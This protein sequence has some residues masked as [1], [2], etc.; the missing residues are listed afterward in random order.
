M[1]AKSK[2]KTASA[3]AEQSSQMIYEFEAIK[4]GSRLYGTIQIIDMNPLEIGALQSA[5]GRACVGMHGD[6]HV[7][8]LGGKSSVG[9][10]RV[11]ITFTGALR[12]IERPATS[13]STELARI[14][15]DS[16]STHI[17]AYL[18]HIRANRADIIE[19][20]QEACE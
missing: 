16:A 6:A 11:A 10:G 8:R 13:E 14:G 2:D 9:F 18:D 3:K 1:A 15:S 12:H 19:A 7:F 4:A 5:L 17:A 20:L